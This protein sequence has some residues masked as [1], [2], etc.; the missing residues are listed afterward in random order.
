MVEIMKVE[1][2]A[3]WDEDLRALTDGLGWLFKPAGAAGDLR[4]DGARVAGR[5]G[6]EET[7][8]VWPSIWVGDSPAVGAPAGRGQVGRG[9]AARAGARLCAAGAGPGRC[10]AGVLVVRC[11][12]RRRGAT[13]SCA[14]SATTTRCP[15]CWPSRW[16]CPCSTC[17]ASHFAPTWCWPIPRTPDGS[18][19]RPVM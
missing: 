8:G 12:L 13:R 4:A 14:S 7:R 15:M 2:I 10:G 5:R 18:G 9:C 3:G 19:V 17:T 11:R 1:D 6:E 16:T